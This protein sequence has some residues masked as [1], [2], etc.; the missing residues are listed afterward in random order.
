MSEKASAVSI[1][2][3]SIFVLV[4]IWYC[5]AVMMADAEVLPG[6][7][8]IAT[9]IIGVLVEPGPEGRSAFF[10]LGI[11]LG[12]TFVTFG[13][14][15]LLGIAIGLAM[16]LRKTIEYSMMSL[17]PLALTMPTILMVFLAVMWF[18]FNEIGSLVAVVGVVTPYVAVNI[19]QG[20]QA[21]DKSVIDMA[22]VFRA[23]KKMMIRK[24]YVPQLLPYIFSAFRFAFGMTW[25]IVA[26]AETFGIKYGIGYMF[27]FWF[28]QFNMELVLA[29]IIM[30]VIL[31]LILEHGVFARLEHAAF[32]WRPANKLQT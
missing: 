14:A 1:R 32:K 17:I 22:T 9:A 5:A 8:A 12:R 10:H 6:P 4:F 28:E 20:A 15:M 3:G 13:V 31:M 29:W 16:G 23:D 2:V 25:K 18:G 19:F 27:F 30:F 21:M 7:L 24:V 11:T 26:L